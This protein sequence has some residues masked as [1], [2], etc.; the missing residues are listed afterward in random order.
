MLN[1]ISKT[2]FISGDLELKIRLIRGI[3]NT[4][5]QIM[6]EFLYLII[7]Y[8][9]ETLDDNKMNKKKHSLATNPVIVIN[10]FKSTRKILLFFVFRFCFCIILFFWKMSLK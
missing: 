9:I 5:T 10:Y 7:C 4:L 6:F 2:I 1:L 3:F 8:F